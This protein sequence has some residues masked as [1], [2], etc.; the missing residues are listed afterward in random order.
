[1]KA[2]KPETA[3]GYLRGACTAVQVAYSNHLQESRQMANYF[4]AVINTPRIECQ[5]RIVAC[6]SKR[7]AGRIVAALV[8]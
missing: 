5:A 8:E 3:G 2:P 4:H 1:M 6:S 7:N